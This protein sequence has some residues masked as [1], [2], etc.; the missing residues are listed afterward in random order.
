[1][2]KNKQDLLQSLLIDCLLMDLNDPTKCTPGLYQVV[3]GVLNDNKE[4]DETIPQET[5][6]FLENRLSDAIPFKKKD[7]S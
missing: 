1:M 7:A 3:R 5:L 2:E 4:S 6:E